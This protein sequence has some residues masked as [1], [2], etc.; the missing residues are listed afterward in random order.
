[1]AYI[2]GL[3][4]AYGANAM[5]PSSFK[6]RD[7]SVHVSRPVYQGL[8][9]TIVGTL[10]A[11]VIMTCT[12]LLLG[13]KAAFQAHQRLRSSIR[14][15]GRFLS[16]LSVN[17]G[18]VAESELSVDLDKLQQILGYAAAEPSF[19]F[20]SLRHPCCGFGDVH[21]HQPFKADLYQELGQRLRSI[22]VFAETLS[23]S[24]RQ[25][26]SRNYELEIGPA[27]TMTSVRSKNY[28]WG[29]PCAMTKG[30]ESPWSTARASLSCPWW[31]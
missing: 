21:W 31:P 2:A 3:A 24:L 26:S 13:S 27:K 9:N 16:Q 5:I 25:A 11:V 1:M 22:S 4:A 23:W 10:L 12:D 28:E 6:L 17:T 15:C 20:A 7:C 8:M 19:T 18:Y 30:S 14:H 29:F